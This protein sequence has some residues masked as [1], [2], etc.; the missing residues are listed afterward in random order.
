MS[1][2]VKCHRVCR[3][4]ERNMQQWNTTSV[5]VFL[6]IRL[7]NCELH[8][9]LSRIKA[10][11]A[12]RSLSRTMSGWEFDW[13]GTCQMIKQASS[14]RTEISCRTKIVF[15]CVLI[16][17][18]YTESKLTWK[19]LYLFFYK[20]KI[21]TFVNGFTIKLMSYCIK[22][23]KMAKR[24]D[25]LDGKVYWSERKLYRILQDDSVRFIL[26]NLNM[27]LPF[28][29][30]YLALGNLSA[31]KSFFITN[32]ICNFYLFQISII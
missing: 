25:A 28:I 15:R 21:K 29:V 31:L 9:S 5:M 16:K 19:I 32:F 7:S 3:I 30:W 22:C 27:L 11:L 10:T 14:M 23:E 6:L 8:G 20:Y 12:G 1:D 13:D 18:C 4:C 17:F 2:F 24:K 26:I